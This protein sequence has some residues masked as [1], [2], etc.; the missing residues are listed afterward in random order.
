MQVSTPRGVLALA[1]LVAGPALAQP[2]AVVLVAKPELAD[3]NFS[4]AVV[5]VTH[6]AGGETI[7]VVLNRPTTLRL[8]DV[9]P[10]FPHAGAYRQPL[11]GGGPVMQAVIVALFRAASPPREA[12]FKV[13]PDAY[14]TL[15]PRLIDSLLDK[16]GR[17]RLF[18]GFSGWAGGQL[19]SE[20]SRDS[21]Y[22]LPA[23]EDLL[24]RSDTSGMW[25]ELLEKARGR[26]A[27]APRKDRGIYLPG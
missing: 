2:A 12:A 21:W 13:L 26:R 15:H 4:E 22:V 1:L 11:Y 24:F 7:G 27:S 8:A 9:A 3:P 6:A 5:L 23:S 14:L 20:I 16:G 18:A 17:M 19:E 10:Q 25:R